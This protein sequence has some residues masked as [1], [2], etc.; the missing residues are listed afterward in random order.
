MVLFSLGASKIIL[1]IHSLLVSNIMD[2]LIRINLISIIILVMILRIIKLGVRVGVQ[3][4]L[5]LGWHLVGRVEGSRLLIALQI[6]ARVLLLRVE[7]GN[8]TITLECS[9]E[10]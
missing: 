9:V 1:K 10:V 7:S 8:L 6:V 4:V 5:I 2:G 3:I